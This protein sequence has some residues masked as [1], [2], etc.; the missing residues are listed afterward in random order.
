[1][2]FWLAVLL[3]IPLLT[4]GQSKQLLNIEL[5]EYLKE[6][7][8]DE[9]VDLFLRGEAAS[10]IAFVNAHQGVIKHQTSQV[11]SCTMPVTAVYLLNEQE[12]IDFVEFEH[13]R[14]TVLN[15][16]MLTNNNINPIH[17]G[18]A[19]LDQAYLGED[20]ILG[21]V[22]AGIELEHPDFQNADGSTRVIALWDQTQD[23]DEPF[24][25][26]EPYGY[27]QEWTPEEIDLGITGH[28]DQAGYYGHGSTVSGVGAGNG[29]ATGQFKGVAP[30]ADIIVVS[31]DFS[32]ENWTSSIADAVDYIF[33]KAEGF[34]KPCVVNLSLGTYYGSHDGLDGAALIMDELVEESPGR[35]VVSAAGNSGNIGN[36][37]LGYEIP[38]ADTAFT[39]FK[40]SGD[41]NGGEGGVFF[42]AWVD[43]ADFSNTQFAVGADQTNPGFEFRGYSDWQ[44][45]ESNLNVSL[46]DTIWY[47][48]AMIGIVETWV[49]LRGEQYQ[50]QVSVRE[51]FSSQYFWRFSTT[52]GGVVDVWSYAG[53]GTSAIAETGLPSVGAYPDM[54]FYQYPDNEKTIVS[55]W[56]CSD[57]VITVGNYANRDEFV[58]YLGE[59]TTFESV[60]GEISI[61]CSRGPTRDYRQKPDIAA[62]GDHTLSTG[63]LAT[64]NTFINNE[65]HK[66]AEDGMHYI[67]GGTSMAS[68]V[69]AGVGAL[70][71]ERDPSATYADV[72]QAIIDNAVADFQTGVLPGN[73]FGY[74][75]L[76]G[77]AVLTE[78]F[79]PTSVGES[80]NS[81]F[82]VYP[83]PV[84]Y[85][86]M[87]MGVDE[88]VA[89]VQLYS[90]NGQLVF[91]HHFEKQADLQKLDLSE[92]PSGL[93]ILKGISKSGAYG[94][95]RIVKE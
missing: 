4:L 47:E 68:P 51:P 38:E 59:I 7:A 46:I 18:V 15:D 21:F 9:R 45:A 90:S 49:G 6:S 62:S 79:E 13:S 33:T 92:L 44:T 24:R 88:A 32:R 14:G 89:T 29:L 61:N 54:A 94:I 55:S 39:W 35:L 58:N 30:Q 16:V 69:V 43:T 40:Y 34:G 82:K 63:R 48:S 52:G 28:D 10:I 93:Y 31:S 56:A 86:L 12:G 53:F 26:P 8:P 75:K 50:I 81:I 72:K 25:I 65:P 70:Y 85:E 77:F 78:P 67:N 91:T 22:D 3:C 11:I 73:Q 23:E 74:G 1:M 5:R 27:G 17:A 57:K 83:N 84:E 37:H 87:I 60:P 76:N 2:R 20:V 95:Q 41:V 19:P 42:E 64:L 80:S 36:Y 71:F 66:V